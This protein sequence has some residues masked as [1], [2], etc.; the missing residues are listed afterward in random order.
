M[1]FTPDPLAI[2]A[3]ATEPGGWE[4]VM[5][6][7][8]AIA[9]ELLAKRFV[10]VDSGRLRASITHTLSEDTEGRVAYVGSDVEY[11]LYQ[12]LEP[13]DTFPAGAGEYAGETRVRRGG[14]PYLRP[15]LQAGVR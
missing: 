15:A 10:N 11:A 6:I 5:L 13:G 12:E 7:R 1:N 2:E 14:Q 4:D 9:V 8:K 3:L